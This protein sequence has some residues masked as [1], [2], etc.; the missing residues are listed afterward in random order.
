MAEAG[1]LPGPWL[2]ILAATLCLKTIYIMKGNKCEL[3]IP[4]ESFKGTTNEKALVDSGATENF[5]NQSMIKRLKLGMKAMDVPVTLR[6]ID[7]TSN[8]A[9]KITHYLNLLVSRGHKKLKEHFFVSNLEEDR[10]ILG[11][12]WL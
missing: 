11:Y 2:A 1:F 7:G 5:I 10:I 6:N 12:P 3:P 8:C 9:G 4:L